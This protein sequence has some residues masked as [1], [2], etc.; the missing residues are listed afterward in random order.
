LQSGIYVALSSQLA[1]DKRL[2]TL[3]DSRKRL[4]TV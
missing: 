1:L 2:T 3:A 4:V